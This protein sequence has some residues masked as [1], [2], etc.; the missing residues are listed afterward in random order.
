MNTESIK[1]KFNDLK[2]NVKDAAQKITSDK[3]TTEKIK[4]EVKDQDFK[5]A[6]KTAQEK[7]SNLKEDEAKRAS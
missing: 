6:A 3:T 1:G 2:D 4:G 7:L 5:G